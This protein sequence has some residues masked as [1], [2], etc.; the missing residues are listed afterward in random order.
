MQIRVTLPSAMLKAF[1]HSTIIRITCTFLVWAAM[2]QGR[3]ADAL[4]G[5]REV[6]SKIPVDMNG[7]AFGAF[8]TFLSQP[9]YVM[10][11]FGMWD[12]LLAEPKP[13]ESNQF[14]LGVWYYARGMA[15]VHSGKMSQAK[16]QLASLRKLRK[17]LPDNYLIGFGTGPR[18][19]TIAEM[20]LAGDYEAK[21]GNYQDAIGHLAR[22]VRL[23]D[24][25]LYNEPPD[26][27]FPTRHVLGSILLDAGFATE[28]AVIFW[29]DLAKN[30]GNGY[31]LT[32]L[33]QAQTAA[34]SIAAAAATK[35]QLD[36]N[37][38]DADVTLTSA[39]Y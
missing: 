14:M 4:A 2:F 36:A 3:S 28:A 7:N 21:K 26:W 20:V 18:L 39:R 38:A 29:E 13:V 1:T 31:G 27:Y 35:A 37:W 8:E 10:V 11:R 16:R 34:G 24:S 22:A 30:P 17:Q 23:E 19:L 9:L 6:Q 25:L 5:A 12:K 15:F 32:G 33:Y